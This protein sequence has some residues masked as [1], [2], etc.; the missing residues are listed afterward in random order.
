MVGILR[1]DGNMV[2]YV[3]VATEA[4]QARPGSSAV[5]G[6]EHLAGAGAEQNVVGIL[7]VVRQAARIA[8][9][10]T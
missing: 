1:V 4:C 9:V 5:I 10:R 6:T 3:F 8:A 2:E 7:R